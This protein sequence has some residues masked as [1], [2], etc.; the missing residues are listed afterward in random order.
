MPLFSIVGMGRISS[1]F[2]CR[3][4]LPVIRTTRS[5]DS[6]GRIGCHRCKYVSTIS[7]ECGLI[8]SRYTLP[9]TTL[10]SQGEASP[11]SSTRTSTYAMLRPSTT[12]RSQIYERF[13]S[14]W[15]LH[16]LV[17]EYAPLHTVWVQLI[18]YLRCENGW[19]EDRRTTADQHGNTAPL[20]RTKYPSFLLF[21]TKPIVTPFLQLVR[22]KY[23]EPVNPSSSSYY[24]PVC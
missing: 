2:T 5:P 19:A 4:F 20:S 13:T 17:G 14:S 22:D 11:L 12:S 3:Q 21:N 1:S 10:G 24:L 8:R 23:V 16:T 18:R 7:M 15:L 9:S 6:D